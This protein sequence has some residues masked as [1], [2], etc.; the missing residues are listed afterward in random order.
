MQY[1][2]KLHAVVSAASCKHFDCRSEPLPSNGM[3]LKEKLAEA[4]LALLTFQ[5]Q[6]R[7]VPGM[8]TLLLP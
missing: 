5:G 4:C 8:P 2:A 7:E 1:Y 3:L 6:D